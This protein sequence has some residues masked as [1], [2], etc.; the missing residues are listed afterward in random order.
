M[1]TYGVLRTLH[2]DNHLNHCKVVRRDARSMQNPL[3]LI[4]HT[5]LFPPHLAA[6]LNMECTDPRVS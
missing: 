2:T 6:I 1:R 3:S 5:A 4:S